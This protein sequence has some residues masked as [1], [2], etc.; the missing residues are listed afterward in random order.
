MKILFSPLGGGGYITNLNS[1]QSPN[2]YGH[3]KRIFFRYFP[4]KNSSVATAMQ[5]F[6]EENYRKNLSLKFIHI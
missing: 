4:S 3:F 1:V 2:L 6:F 5:R